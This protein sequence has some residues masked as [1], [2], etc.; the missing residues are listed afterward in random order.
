MHRT[1]PWWELSSE[2]KIERDGLRGPKWAAGAQP[3]SAASLPDFGGSTRGCDGGSA[4][5]HRR[6]GGHVLR[7]NPPQGGNEARCSIRPMSASSPATLAQD[8]AGRPCWRRSVTER[9]SSARERQV[10]AIGVDC[11]RSQLD[12]GCSSSAASA[13]AGLRLRLAARSC[14]PTAFARNRLSFA[15]QRRRAVARRF[16]RRGRSRQTSRSM[17]AA[18]CRR[19]S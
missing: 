19:A 7:R 9:L 1:P 14:C 8:R 10:V 18:G 15:R 16:P 12:L 2:L 6:A 3:P 4:A 13:T 11:S 17:I 5:S